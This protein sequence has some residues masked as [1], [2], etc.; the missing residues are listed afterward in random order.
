MYYTKCVL[1]PI[2]GGFCV[3]NLMYFSYKSWWSWFI[4]SMA[5]ARRHVNKSFLGGLRLRLRLY[6]HDAVPGPRHR[7]ADFR[8]IFINYKLK[9]VAHMP[10]RV[11]IYKFFSTFIDRIVGLRP[12]LDPRTTSTPSS[13]HMT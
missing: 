6:Q 4:S 8:Q 1:Y 5:G 2:A 10:W 11:L 13:S 12:R 9:S 3:Y 7:K